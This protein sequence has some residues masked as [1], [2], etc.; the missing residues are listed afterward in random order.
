[1]NTRQLLERLAPLLAIGLLVAGCA[2]VLAPFVTALLW[3]GIVSYTTWGW[4][5]RLTALLGGRRTLAVTL[6]MGVLLLV[7]V[8]PL[9][10]GLAGLATEARSLAELVKQQLADGLPPLPVWLA[11]L[12]WV[13]SRLQDWWEGLASGDPAITEQ[14]KAAMTWASKGMLFVGAAVGQGL[15]LLVLSSLLVPFFYLGGERAQPWLR[16]AM[17]RLAG[18]RTDEVLSIA[19]LTVRSAVLGIV[20]TALVQGVLAGIGYAIAGVPG[21]MVLSLLTALLSLVPAG[22]ALLWVPAALWLYHGGHPGWAIFIALW[23]MLVVGLADNVVK[24]LLMG[25]GS[26]LPFLLVM[27]GAMGGALSFGLLGVFIGPTLLAVGFSLLRD[28]VLAPREAQL[29]PPEFD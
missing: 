25:K 29:P 1:M 16:G 20:G 26:N 2:V 5:Q 6:M 28:W 17:E 18:S 14:L 8:L 10:Y 21:A 23:G 3:A 9:V 12:P 4:F 11:D 7:L 22:P 27:L 24:P 19:G 15:W 13:G